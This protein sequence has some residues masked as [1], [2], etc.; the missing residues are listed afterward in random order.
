M[1]DPL[2][3]TGW[4]LDISWLGRAISKLAGGRG[5]AGLGLT[6]PRSD[7]DGYTMVTPPHRH[8]L[9]GVPNQTCKRWWFDNGEYNTLSR[10]IGILDACL[11][12]RQYNGLT[13]HFFEH[14]H[15][16]FR[17]LCGSARRPSLSIV[18]LTG[19]IDCLLTDY[20][21]LFH[22]RKFPLCFSSM[23]QRH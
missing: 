13:M 9:R 19:L 16:N 3:V 17:C 10:I 14:K 20:C 23:R 7:A 4:P 5:W 21:V 2:K 15:R 11:Q 8:F 1:A 12:N 22:T 6:T 18:L